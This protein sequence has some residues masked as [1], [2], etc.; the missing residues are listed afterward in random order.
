MNK[1]KNQDEKEQT[2]LKVGI[3]IPFYNNRKTLRHIVEQS[4]KNGLP[5]FVVDDGSTDNGLESISDLDCHK[6]RLA[7]NQG[8]GAALVHGAK[9][10]EDTGFTHLITLDADAQHNPAEVPLFLEKIQEEPNALILGNRNFKQAGIPGKSAFGRKWSNL[11]IRIASG[12]SVT[13]S[14][15]GFRAYPVQILTRLK[16]LSKRYNFEI[17]I[18]VKAL[19]AGFPVDSIDVSVHYSEETKAGSHFRPFKDNLLISLTYARL[20]L[21]NMLPVP[22]KRIIGESAPKKIRKYL[23]R[24]KEF[25]KLLLFESLSIKEIV[26]ALGLG[27]FLGTFPLVGIHSIAIVFVA[28]R[29]KLNRL[30]ALNISHL[31]APPFVPALCVEAGHFLRFGN[32]ISTQ[33]AG[34]NGLQELGHNPLSYIGDYFLGAV[35]MAPILAL[36]VA[37]FSLAILFSIRLIKKAFAHGKNQK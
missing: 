1:P 7:K 19:W 24:P 35:V 27:I 33:L 28:S 26:L 6:S 17:E 37:L 25:I 2:V 3:L 8:K 10:A 22:H 20:V 16:A 36:L 23:L 32:F 11:W 31:C 12:F 5:V 21:R 30:I 34:Q 18:L 29:L 14:Q 13:D 15:S 9:I 4:L